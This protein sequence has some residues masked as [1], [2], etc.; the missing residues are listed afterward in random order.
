[1]IATLIIIGL[2]FAWLGYETDWMRV[3]LLIGKEGFMRLPSGVLIT[4]QDYNYLVAIIKPPKVKTQAT[5]PCWYCG[6]GHDRQ[7]IDDLHSYD[8]CECGASIVIWSKKKARTATANQ[9]L[10][11]QLGAKFAPYH[12]ANVRTMKVLI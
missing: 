2:A 8:L 10:A 4:E 7:H 9:R 12:Q 1:M 11:R 3:R 5:A 6:N